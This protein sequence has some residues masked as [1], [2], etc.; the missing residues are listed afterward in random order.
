MI[1]FNLKKKKQHNIYEYNKIVHLLYRIRFRK[2]KPANILEIILYNV[3][4]YQM[5][6]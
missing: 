3:S 2:N 4:K 5:F 6:E 1:K